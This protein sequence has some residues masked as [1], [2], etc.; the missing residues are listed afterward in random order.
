MELKPVRKRPRRESLKDKIDR[1][2]RQGLVKIRSDVGDD[3]IG[4]ACRSDLEIGDF[5][6]TYPG[7]LISAAEAQKRSVSYTASQEACLYEFSWQNKCWY[8][9]G[10]A[11]KG[12]GNFVNHSRKNPNTTTKIYM[13][14]SGKP[15][16]YFQARDKIPALTE[17][18]YDYGVVNSEVPWVANT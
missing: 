7:E 9:D 1:G 6:C 5:I 12:I 18:K 4:V 13:T 16:M 8:I 3:E 17:I 15:I 11:K 10:S 2:A 14:P